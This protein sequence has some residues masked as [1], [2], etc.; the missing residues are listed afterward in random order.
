MA[1]DTLIADGAE[2]PLASAVA[3]R[4][5]DTLRMVEAAVAARNALLV[6]QPVVSGTHPHRPVYYE[7]LIRVLDATGRIIPARDFIAAVER[8]PVGRMIDCLALEMGLAALKAHPRLRLYVNM[9]ARSI[10]YARWQRSLEDGLRADPGIGE[11]LILEI[12]EPSAMVM[13]DVV[14]AFMAD[15]Q[16]RGL[17]F[18]IDDFGAGFTSLRYLLDMDFDFVKI[19]GQIVRGLAASADNRVLI[20]TILSIARHFRMLTVAESVETAQE[21][22]WLARSGVDCLQG[23]HFGAPTRTP[24]FSPCLPARPRGQSR[25]QSRG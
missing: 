19:D 22:T 1:I 2:S 3:D 15:L 12:T 9:S 21:A 10:G 5:R 20:Q 24:D 16:G 14:Q 11:R 4:D 6:Y 18:A 25:G 8:H 13:P 17:S 23:Y 7:G